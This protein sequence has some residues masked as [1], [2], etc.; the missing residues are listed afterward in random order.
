MEYVH[1]ENGIT[2]ES[3]RLLLTLFKKRKA[4]INNLKDV[5]T[6]E[7]GRKNVTLADHS[8]VSLCFA[9]GVLESVFPIAKTEQSDAVRDLRSD[10]D[11][12]QF[13]VTNTC[14]S[15]KLVSEAIC[16]DFPRANSP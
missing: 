6:N 12:A 7:K 4:L 14:N 8:C 9:S 16:I 5:S 1:L 3:S 13:I 10:I 2:D 11:F 15:L